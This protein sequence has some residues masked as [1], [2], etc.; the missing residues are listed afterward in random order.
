MPAPRMEADILLHVVKYDAFGNPEEN[1]NGVAIRVQVP[2]KARVKYSTERIFTT[3]G[4]E[5]TATLEVTL[6]TETEVHDGDI[7]EWVDRFGKTVK[8]PI[9]KMRE[10]LNPSGEIVWYRKAWTS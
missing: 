1:R 7:V 10:V 8:G 3:S 6:P 5:S 4:E 2:S 9:V